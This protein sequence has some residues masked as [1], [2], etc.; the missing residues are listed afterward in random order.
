MAGPNNKAR[1]GY[2]SDRS[3]QMARREA[4]KKMMESRGISKPDAA[5]PD[6]PGVYRLKETANGK[7]ALEVDGIAAVANRKPGDDVT[8]NGITYTVDSV[9]KT[10]KAGPRDS[11]VYLYVKGGA[12]G[13]RTERYKTSEQAWKNEDEGAWYRLK[14]QGK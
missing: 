11:R 9:G 3:F 12:G 4:V 5:K 13:P 2:E 14:Q 6:T 10:F 7:T 8:H 1:K